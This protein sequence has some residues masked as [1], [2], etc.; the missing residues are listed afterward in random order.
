M[1][2]PPRGLDSD[3]REWTETSPFLSIAILCTSFTFQTYR[4]CQTTT[5]DG[6]QEWL[7]DVRWIKDNRT[8]IEHV[9]FWLVSG[10]FADNWP[11]ANI[12]MIWSPQKGI[13]MPFTVSC[14][15]NNCLLCV[16]VM[17]DD[18]YLATPFER[19]EPKD[20]WLA[21]WCHLTTAKLFLKF[22]DARVVR[23]NWCSLI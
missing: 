18:K 6:G 9:R 1:P 21:G 14:M 3:A 5:C 7:G 10:R 13:R 12:S 22:R 23:S 15:F 2:V 16:N 17:G 8:S 11:R 20:L 19:D 4:E